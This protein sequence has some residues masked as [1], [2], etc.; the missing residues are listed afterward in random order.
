MLITWPSSPAPGFWPTWNVSVSSHSGLYVNVYSSFIHKCQKL[1]TSQ[2]F[3]N[4]WIDK[5]I[6]VHS[7]DEMPFS[8]GKGTG[9]CSDMDGSQKYLDATNVCIV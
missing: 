6:V 7:C 4:W 1:E 9:M 3:M 8:N 2:M 5:Q